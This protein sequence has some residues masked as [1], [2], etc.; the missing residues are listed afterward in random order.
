MFHL[1]SIILAWLLALSPRSAL[2]QNLPTSKQGP[3]HS[4]E[5]STI[6]PADSAEVK[7]LVNDSEA[8]PPEFSADVSLTL[9]E[10]GLVRDNA[11]KI[12]LL[13][14]AFEKAAAAQ[15][16]VMQR[17]FGSSV[18]ETAEGL[19]AIASTVT[20]LNRTSLQ[21]RVIRQFVA[22]DPHRARR[23]FESMP[24][25]HLMEIPC[26]Q[27]WYFFPDD[28]Y[29]ALE[30]VLETGF[31]NGEIAGGNRAAYVSSIISNAQ[32]HIQTALI[33]R[34]LNTGDFTEQE[35][36]TIMPVYAAVLRRLHGDSLSF[37]ILMWRPN[38]FFDAISTLLASLDKR[39]LD[40]RPV[41]HAFRDYIVSNFKGPNCDTAKF[42]INPE[43]GL[44]N[45]IVRFNETFGARLKAANLGA[46]GAEEIKSDTI[47]S[48]ESPPPLARWNSP[49]YSQLLLAVQGLNPPPNAKETDGDPKD[50][51]PRWLSKAQNVL[52]QLNSWSNEGEAESES[53][54]FH[55]K[56]ILL[57]G[58]AR[59]T[60]GTPLN[61]DA[62][63]SFVQ[64]LE[65]NSYDEVTPID[66]FVSAELVFSMNTKQNGP[67]ADFRR[68]INSRDPVLSVYGRLQSLLQSAEQTPA[69]NE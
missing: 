19:H 23:M 29:K 47:N 17:S 61:P 13:T 48:G 26:N 55:Q 36:R 12:K 43:F 2:T 46:I 4:H 65:Q 42:S 15:D 9:V 54:F 66:W 67:R 5:R 63:D 33:T 35:L 38:G 3:Q 14:R 69:D 60:I 52:T 39:N 49:K 58:L 22:V 37:H 24:A 30:A 18:E 25:A 28:Y 40:S 10:N 32:Y 44:P 56:A 7:V 21:S 59:R 45:P 27:D 8:L 34:L 53:D 57:G 62:L 64:F 51:D 1:R 20:G 68:F 16:D 11:L 31:S 41:L 50:K 6:K